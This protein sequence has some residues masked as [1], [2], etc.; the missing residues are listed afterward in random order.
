[1]MIMTKC[2]QVCRVISTAQSARDDVVHFQVLCFST[3]FIL[4]GTVTGYDPVPQ[5]PPEEVPVLSRVG[6]FVCSSLFYP[7][8]FFYQTCFFIP[9]N[10]YMAELDTPGSSVCMAVFAF[11][12][13]PQL[14]KLMSFKLTPGTCIAFIFQAIFRVSIFVMCTIPAQVF[15]ASAVRFRIFR[16]IIHFFISLTY[17]LI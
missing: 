4:T 10:I 1:M 13:Q 15:S 16:L 7:A 5:G 14:K 2:D 3:I 6:P 8:G 17:F 12:H 11:E 9:G